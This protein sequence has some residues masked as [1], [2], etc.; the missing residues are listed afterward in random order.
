MP[1]PDLPEP[2]FLPGITLKR[3][4]YEEAVRPILAERFPALNYAAALIGYGSD[5][6]G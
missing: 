4:N 1:E 2:D 5:V 6:L 3:A